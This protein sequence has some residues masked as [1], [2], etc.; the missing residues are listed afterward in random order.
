MR[1]DLRLRPTS[2]RLPDGKCTIR[3]GGSGRSEM[4]SNIS[5]HVPGNISHSQNTIGIG[6]SRKTENDEASVGLAIRVHSEF[7]YTVQSD[8]WKMRSRET[9][10]SSLGLTHRTVHFLVA[11]VSLPGGFCIR[12]H[13]V[14]AFS[15][16]MSPSV[17]VPLGTNPLQV[18]LLDS[19]APAKSGKRGWQFSAGLP[20]PTHPSE[21]TPRGAG[22]S[23]RP[24]QTSLPLSRYVSP[25]HNLLQI[26]NSYYRFIC[27]KRR[28]NLWVEAVIE[29][30]TRQALSCV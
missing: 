28:M 3:S 29:Y 13:P 11:V 8:S 14:L 23:F 18:I 19:P 7:V 27:G 10:S 5:R 30:E 24:R 20:A 25:I 17:I 12:H 9:R 15:V 22:F 16:V 6:R 21:R 1:R 2:V 26:Y 4:C